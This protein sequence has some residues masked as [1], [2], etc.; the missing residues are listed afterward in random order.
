[1]EGE[2]LLKCE[3]DSEIISHIRIKQSQSATNTAFR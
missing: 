1:M 2:L 3:S